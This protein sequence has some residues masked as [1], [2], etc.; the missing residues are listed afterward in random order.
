M[1]H[2][3]PS[4]WVAAGVALVGA[5]AIAAT[6]VDVP[7]PSL[8]RLQAHPV[9]L[10]ASWSDV[11]AAAEA[12]AGDIWNHFSA[13]PFP[14]L[15]QQLANQIGYVQGLLDGSL[16]FNDVIQDIADHATA[17]F[18]APA[19]GDTPADPG[20]L[21]GPF[22]PEGGPTDTLYQSLDTTVNSTGTGLFEIITL[23]HEQLSLLLGDALPNLL[24]PLGLDESALPLVQSLLDFSESPLSGV[25]VGQIGTM[26]SPVL[27]FNDDVHA[28][29]DALFGATPDWDTALQSL[30]N[31]PAN[32]T[33][34]YLN[35]YGSVDLLPLLDQLGIDL[36]TI[37]LIAGLPTDVTG[38]DLE[39]GGL[40]SG[41][42]SLFDAIGLGADGG[43]DFGSLDLSGL[44]VGPIASLVELGQSIAMSLGWDGVSE[45]L[46]GLF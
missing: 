6:P 30:A 46:S 9:E 41:G 27:Q 14:A 19:S 39:L 29:S 16:N 45:I 1:Q 25:L 44:A 4:P 8:P 28:I 17:V 37:E 13:V 43:P 32:I 12:N 24:E 21:F 11:L 38:L 22:L 40:L 3:I 2:T 5:G 42:G 34:A 15:E 20:A 10:T 31:M 35:G 18:G 26:L 23:N 7:L 36:P 33:D